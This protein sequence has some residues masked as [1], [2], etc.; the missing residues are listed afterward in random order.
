MGLYA[1]G[2]TRILRGIITI[3]TLLVSGVVIFAGENGNFICCNF[4]LGFVW[5]SEAK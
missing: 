2:C 4:L 5:S 1:Q 3:S